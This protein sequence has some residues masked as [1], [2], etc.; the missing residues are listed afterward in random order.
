[1]PTNQE[2]DSILTELSQADDPNVIL[3]IC[4]RL[5][6]RSKTAKVN[7]EYQ[8]M[9]NNEY[10]KGNQH[11]RANDARNVLVSMK[12][13]GQGNKLTVNMI[14]LFLR[15]HISNIMR[16][17]PRFRVIPVI[18]DSY[19]DASQ[20]MLDENGKPKP[21]LRTGAMVEMAK[22]GTDLLEYILDQNRF[23][24]TEF[25]HLLSGFVTGH[26]YYEV[27]WDPAM[28]NAGGFPG[29]VGIKQRSFWSVYKDDLS[30][31]MAGLNDARWVIHVEPMDVRDIREKFNID[32]E[33]DNKRSSS[34]FEMQSRVYGVSSASSDSVLLY[35]CWVRVPYF[36]PYMVQVGDQQVQAEDGGGYIDHK[37]ECYIHTDNVFIKKIDDPLEIGEFP[38]ACTAIEPVINEPYAHGLVKDLIP[39]Q[40]QVNRRWTQIDRITSLNSNPIMI[41]NKDSGIKKSD[42]NN[43]FGMVLMKEPD[44]LPPTIIQGAS[45]PPSVIDA[46]QMGI[47]QLQTL[48]SAQDALLGKMPPGVT[49][50]AQVQVILDSNVAAT[51]TWINAFE[52]CLREL[53]RKV[54][55]VAKA[56][57]PQQPITYTT[58]N[59]R[60]QLVDLQFDPVKFN[61]QDVRVTI[62]E[63]LSNTT[64]GRIENAYTMFKLGLQGKQETLHKLDIENGTEIWKQRMQELVEE[65]KMMQAIPQQP[66]LPPQTMEQPQME[67]TGLPPMPPP[68]DGMPIA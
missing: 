28:Q 9:V 53:A 19:Y 7:Y 12:S 65:A 47:Q 49:S 60:G 54:L 36:K 66:A 52:A 44:G 56:K 29:N 37:I 1:M 3:G 15:A 42:L 27:E 20:T 25:Q 16:R 23:T 34:V 17:K 43:R 38:F 41:L 26:G 11:L 62:E 18:D 39:S 4:K 46:L 32:V 50:G 64:S 45:V 8:A 40:D 6:E 51:G 61:L 68:P 24:D 35:R 21:A 58:Y 30:T 2:V 10:Y 59:N 22:Q 31:D 55:K 67:P 33:P 48:A 14:R 57:Y 13:T 63:G 5:F